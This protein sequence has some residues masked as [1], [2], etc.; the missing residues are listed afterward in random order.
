MLCQFSYSVFG[1][2]SA[3]YV[4]FHDVNHTIIGNATFNDIPFFRYIKSFA[5][6]NDEIK[7]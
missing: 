1:I 2:H 4:T 6:L 3:V 7:P 5:A